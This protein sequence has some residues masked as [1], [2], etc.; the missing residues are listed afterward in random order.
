MN[1]EVMTSSQHS[2]NASIDV[3]RH[4]LSSDELQ[5]R[6]AEAY[7]FYYPLVLMEF[8]R[9]KIRANDRLHQPTPPASLMVRWKSTV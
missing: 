2:S 5:I 4:E 8:T 6:A 9:R 3:N 1:R 7:L